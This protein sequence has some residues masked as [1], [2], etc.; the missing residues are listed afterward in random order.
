MKNIMEILKT[1]RGRGLFK[2]GVFVIFFIFVAVLFHSGGDVSNPIPQPV[3]EK[4][5][6]EKYSE[7]T[8]YTYRYQYLDVIINGKVYRD[9]LYFTIDENN[10]VVKDGIVYLNEEVTELDSI[11]LYD[12]HKIA[13]LID[14]DK[15][16]SKNEDYSLDVVT[17]T[18]SV[19]VTKIDS[20][21]DIMNITLSEKDNE[22]IEAVITIT[23]DDLTSSIV[24][25]YSLVN[26]T[27]LVE[28]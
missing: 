9:I 22:I 18:Y 5:A 26:Q 21:Y 6:L 12:N 3:K 8:N 7:M 10:Y 19:D 20:I 1:E 2:L 16:I 27:K 4:T 23:K 11:Y 13:S 15:I 25:D 28:E 14:K 17:T 24:I